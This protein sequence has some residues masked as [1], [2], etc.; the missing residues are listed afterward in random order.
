MLVSLPYP[1][2]PELEIC[3]LN[4]RHIH[5]LWLLPITE[6]ER[7]F[8]VEHGQEALEQLFDES[9]LEYW[10]DDRESVVHTAV[11]PSHTA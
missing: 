11:W 9:R 7:D 6:D 5:L 1:F 2:G 8:K 3:N 4:D 10:R